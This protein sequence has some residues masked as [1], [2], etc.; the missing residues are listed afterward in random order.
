[1]IKRVSRYPETS[2]GAP[3]RATPTAR[4]AS[5]LLL[6]AL[7]VAA[8]ALAACTPSA[9][10]SPPAQPT[11]AG[12]E[13]ETQQVPVEGG[14]FYTDVGPAGLARMLETK[15][16]PLINVHVPYEGEIE[17]TDLFIPYTEIGANLDKLPADKNARIVLYC[18]SGSMSAIAAR[19]L[20]ANGYTDVWNLDGGMIA[21]QDAGYPLA[22]KQH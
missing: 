6:T 1:M 5:V 14:G 4:P 17:P 19:E 20:V 8:F 10:G 15:D 21:W 16:F 22:H 7:L 18:R 2:A 3:L 13:S 9:S 12:D 11:T